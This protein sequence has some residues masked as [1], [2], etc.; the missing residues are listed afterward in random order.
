MTR[1]IFETKIKVIE[2]NRMVHDD[3]KSVMAFQQASMKEE[4]SRNIAR[5]FRMCEGIMA[6]NRLPPV[7]RTSGVH[8]G[9]HKWSTYH[10]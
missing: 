10:G 4:N 3:K 7:Q 1:I 8:V 2:E 5:F 9:S 6:D